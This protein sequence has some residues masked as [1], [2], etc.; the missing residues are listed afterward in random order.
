MT[1]VSLSLPVVRRVKILDRN[2]RVLNDCIIAD[3]V[4]T[5]ASIVEEVR[6]IHEA[7]VADEVVGNDLVLQLLA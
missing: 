3:P 5:F 6:S 2:G 7:P 1:K 4:R